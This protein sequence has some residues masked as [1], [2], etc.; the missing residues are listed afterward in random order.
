M[1]G[2][3]SLEWIICQTLR[4]PPGWVAI[5]EPS[6]VSLG[7][8][9]LGASTN[10]HWL[11]FVGLVFLVC[12][13]QKLVSFI[14]ETYKVSGPVRGGRVDVPNSGARLWLSR[15]IVLI[16][17]GKLVRSNQNCN[18][19]IFTVDVM[20][21]SCGYLLVLCVC[22]STHSN[23]GIHTHMILLIYIRIYIYTLYIYI[24]MI[25]YI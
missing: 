21:I 4:S 19:V 9:L 13:W 5:A 25:I 24:Y 6:C 14:K 2:F 23:P 8:S 12:A 15:R 18:L 22:V 1:F 16:L 10:R 17:V 11:V 7:K 20:V 3:P